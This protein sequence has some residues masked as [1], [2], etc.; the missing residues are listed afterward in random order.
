MCAPALSSVGFGVAMVT[1]LPPRASSARVGVGSD[2]IWGFANA[3]SSV[4]AVPPTGSSWH[5]G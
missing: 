4:W 1:G 5:T 2:V 3:V